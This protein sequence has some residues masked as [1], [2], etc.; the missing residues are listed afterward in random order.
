M[1]HMKILEDISFCCGFMKADGRKIAKYRKRKP[2]EDCHD[3]ALEMPYKYD[4]QA[5]TPAL[6]I[7]KILRTNQSPPFLMWQIYD[8]ILHL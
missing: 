3:R 8:N 7:S 2:P 6:N 5:L 4:L 1:A